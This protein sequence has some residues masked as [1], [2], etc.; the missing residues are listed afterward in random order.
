MGVCF[1]FMAMAAYIFPPLFT[2]SQFTSSYLFLFFCDFFFLIVNCTV[3]TVFKNFREAFCKPHLKRFSVLAVHLWIL[4]LI[5]YLVSMSNE[6]WIHRV[7]ITSFLVHTNIWLVWTIWHLS[8]I[9]M[10]ST[11]RLC[12]VIVCMMKIKTSQYAVSLLKTVCCMIDMWIVTHVCVQWR[13]G[14]WSG[15]NGQ[16]RRYHPM[17]CDMW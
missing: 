2:C 5:L 1:T 15:E 6:G 17:H 8:N 11:W 14:C 7:I 12:A 9:N 10:G 16:W 4:L 13:N 3:S